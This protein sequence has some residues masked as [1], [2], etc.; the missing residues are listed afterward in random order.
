MQEFCR[1]ICFLSG[2]KETASPPRVINPDFRYEQIYADVA[3]DLGKNIYD[4]L[5]RGPRQRSDRLQRRLKSGKEA[6]IYKVVLIALADMQP[7]VETI[8][9]EPLRSS[10]RNI[11]DDD[12]PQAHEVS[13]VLEQMA[14]ISATDESSVPVID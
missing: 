11:L 14:K 2:I 5:A 13:R 9:Y 4:K 3:Q 6:D 1:K 8:E 10:I 7:G 12:L